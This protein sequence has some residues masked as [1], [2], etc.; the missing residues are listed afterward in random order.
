MTARHKV[1]G[2]VLLL[3]TATLV[4]LAYTTPAISSQQTEP[5]ENSFTET[6][7]RMASAIEERYPI[8]ATAHK[9]A[10]ALR[11]GIR[12]GAIKINDGE[13]FLETTNALMWGAAQDLHLRLSTEE[14]IRQRM[15]RA[16]GSRVPTMRRVRVPQDGSPLGTT[17][18]TS[19]MLNDTTGLV[20]ISSAIYRNPDL[21]ADA[22]GKVK[23]AQNIIIDLRT[24]PGG[25][26]P[27]VLNFISHFYDQKT[28]VYSN[29]SRQFNTP[30]EVWTEETSLG[31]DFAD[32]DLYVL[33][34]RRTASGAEA[35]S[36]GLKNT[37]RATLVGEKTAGAGNGG[38]FMAVGQGLM[39]FLPT[40][41]TINAKT[42]EPWEGTGV[43]PHLEAE[44]EGALV[45]ALSLIANNT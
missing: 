2:G 44:A 31:N 11:S 34:S 12:S 29:A 6:L 33:T 24:V 21:F 38:A 40:M 15:S 14:A 5:Q 39:L 41:Q 10:D 9:I 43:V 7:D 45:A 25:T 18:I 28:H 16:G 20:A 1:I 19:E 26:V 4:P 23:N 3:A 30:Q 22:L 32:K 8:E 27:G 37:E 17:D 13:A 36:F 35:I 42:G